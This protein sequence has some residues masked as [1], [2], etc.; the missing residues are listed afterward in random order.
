MSICVAILS[1]ELS[2]HVRLIIG[3]LE[4]LGLKIVTGFFLLEN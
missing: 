1:A 4:N 2:A 3:V